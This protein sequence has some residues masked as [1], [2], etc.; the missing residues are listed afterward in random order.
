MVDSRAGDGAFLKSRIQGFGNAPELAPTPREPDVEVIPEV[1]YLW[2]ALVDIGETM[3]LSSVLEAVDY[4]VNGDANRPPQKEPI[5]EGRGVSKRLQQ[6]G[7]GTYRIRVKDVSVSATLEL[8][9]ECLDS[10]QPGTI[11]EVL[12]VVY[13]PY[14]QR[15]RGKIEKGWISLLNTEDG[16][17]WVSKERKSSKSNTV[18][19]EGLNQP[20]PKNDSLVDRP[21]RITLSPKQ[22]QLPDLLILD[23]EPP[24]ESDDAAS[25]MLG[26]YSVDEISFEAPIPKIPPPPR[27]PLSDNLVPDDLIWEAEEAGGMSPAAL[28]DLLASDAAM[29]SEPAQ[30][31]L[32]CQ[33]TW[34]LQAPP[35]GISLFDPLSIEGL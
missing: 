21:R 12:D 15:L 20:A 29:D 4:C 11:V 1:D 25:S 3:G 8:G 24:A 17:Y 2:H 22:E 7:P 16:S 28:T 30:V 13:R 14:E 10:L 32:P 6:W 31:V 9:G 33:S 19:K 27:Q 23:D 18:Q 5:S 34:K 26:V 35:R